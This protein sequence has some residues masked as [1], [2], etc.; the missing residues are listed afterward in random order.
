[1]QYP[2][3]YYSLVVCLVGTLIEFYKDRNAT[4][5]N[6]VWFLPVVLAQLWWVSRING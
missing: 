5:F 4:L 3:V 2:I 6:D 1:M